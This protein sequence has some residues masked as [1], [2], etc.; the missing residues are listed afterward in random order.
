[1]TTISTSAVSTDN[2]MQLVEKQI[3]DKLDNL[4]IAILDSLENDDNGNAIRLGKEAINTTTKHSD[5]CRCQILPFLY[6]LSNAYYNTKD[7]KKASQCFSSI[8]RDLDSFPV[9]MF[10][11]ILAAYAE[12]SY[13]LSDRDLAIKLL[14]EAL[15]VYYE[16][17]LEDVKSYL[18]INQ[19][20][21]LLHLEIKDMNMA[22]GC[23]DE[24]LKTSCD[25]CVYVAR[26][27]FVHT[28][29]FLFN[30][31]ES[32]YYHQAEKYIKLVQKM[33]V[34]KFDGDQYMLGLVYYLFSN[35]YS[36]MKKPGKSM[37]FH[38]RYVALLGDDFFV[39]PNCNTESLALVA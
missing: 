22:L 26:D 34:D 4:E 21:A 1:M 2:V 24:V 12:T 8:Y 25:L 38:D 11:Q 31:T 23:Y 10:P 13:K 20:L 28:Y 9:E 39:C 27:N 35:L 33:I 5:F 30:L 29:N 7:F 14:M 36:R 37:K 6:Y 32:G 15:Y 16:A 18:K 19:L 17:E 3:K